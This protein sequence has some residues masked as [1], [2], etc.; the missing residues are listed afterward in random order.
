MNKHIFSILLICFVYLAS[1]QEK[2]QKKGGL[3]TAD[4]FQM[5][6]NADNN[7]QIIDVRTPEEFAAGYISGAV[8]INFYD[9]DFQQKINLLDKNKSVFVYCKGGG[10]SAEAASMMKNAGFSSVYELKGG[11]MGWENAGKPIQHSIASGET[12]FE[13]KK[14]HI[15]NKS[16]LDSVL[17]T[18]NMV[19]VD[20]YAKW[21]LPCKKM[22]PVLEELEQEN[23]GKV[24]FYKVEVDDAKQLCKEL[25]IEGPPVIKLYVSGIEKGKLIGL[26]S[27][28]NIIQLINHR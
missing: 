14:N 1:C 4:D 20:F 6:M 18:N 10:R 7:K 28:E 15:Y 9:A 13:K 27:K 24:Y 26:Q 17:R 2:S 21:C 22:K 23:A 19:L 11:I 25:N 5:E 12:A 16:E 3:L 8:L